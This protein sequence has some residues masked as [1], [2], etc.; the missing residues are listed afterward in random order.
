[1][2]SLTA[3]RRLVVKIGSALLVDRASGSLRLEAKAGIRLVD[4][5]DAEVGNGFHGSTLV[6]IRN[7]TV[8]LLQHGIRTRQVTRCVSYARHV[9]CTRVPL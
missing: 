4:G 3:S 5:G 1:M 6:G 8:G 7:R 9:R 2:A